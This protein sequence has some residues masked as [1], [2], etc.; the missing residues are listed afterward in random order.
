MALTRLAGLLG[1]VELDR[2]ASRDGA[3][4]WLLDAYGLREDPRQAAEQALETI[5]PFIHGHGGEVEVLGVTDGIVRVRMSGACAGCT[6]SAVTL[7]DGVEEALRDGMPGFAGL[8]VVEDEAEPHPPP[9][10]TLVQIQPRP[11]S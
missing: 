1:E 2:L 7:R 6:A 5:R 4:A 11:P 9:G 10:P 8:D 3:V